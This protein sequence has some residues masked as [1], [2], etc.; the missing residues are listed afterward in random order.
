MQHELLIPKSNNA[1][2]SFSMDMED[3]D[4]LL[5]EFALLKDMFLTHSQV[6][7]KFSK[8]QVKTL[9]CMYELFQ[10]QMLN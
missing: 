6:K 5:M 7:E 2:L 10:L 1:I 9:P 3:I 8:E 4:V